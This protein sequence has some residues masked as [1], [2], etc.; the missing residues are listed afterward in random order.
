VLLVA[1]T[2]CARVAIVFLY[3][4]STCLLIVVV[5]VRLGEF[6]C[7]IRVCSYSYQPMH[8]FKNRRGV[9]NNSYFALTNET[10]IGTCTK[11]EVN[12]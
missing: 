6:I 1:K 3:F 9:Q 8:L 4:V 12:N 11:Q 10:T 7:S 2:D 5:V